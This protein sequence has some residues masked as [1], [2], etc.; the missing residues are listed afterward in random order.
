MSNKQLIIG[1]C[2]KQG[3]ELVPQIAYVLATVE[4]ETNKTFEPVK[5]AYWLSENWRKNNLRYYPY[6][7]RGFVQ[8]T[9]KENYK[10]FSDILNQDFVSNPDK[11][12]NPNISAFILVYGFKH[13][14]FTGKK[15][16]DYINERLVDYY[17]ARR[18]INGTDKA[19]SIAEI[20][21]KYEKELS[22]SDVI[23]NKKKEKTINLQTFLNG[24]GYGL[25]VDGIYG[26]NTKKA[27][28]TFVSTL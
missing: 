22:K 2:Y 18:C 10:K 1:E 21:E 17:G 13:G 3:I 7:G 16:S 19:Y 14:I 27:L 23:I 4:W 6:Y 5:E 9:W 25:V 8:I 28:D 24:Y 15:I 12:M 20:A 11:V 26:K